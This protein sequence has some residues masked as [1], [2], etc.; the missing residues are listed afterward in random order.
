M[1]EDYWQIVKTI[2]EEEQNGQNRAEYGK[3]LIQDLSKQLSSEFGKGFDSRNLW[4][5]KQFYLMF[6]KVNALRSELSWTHYRLLLKVE[7][8]E[9]R[10]FYMEECV[11]ENWSTRQLERQISSFYYERILKSKDKQSVCSEIH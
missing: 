4:Y 2:L 6:P 9:T 5:M 3:R 8:E 11:Q 7:K 1:V 10:K